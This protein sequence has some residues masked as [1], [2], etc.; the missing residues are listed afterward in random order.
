MVDITEEISVGELVLVRHGQASFN[1]DNYDRLSV[2]GERQ[3]RILGRFFASRDIEFSEAVCGDMVRHSDTL[4]AVLQSTD[5]ARPPIRSVHAGLNEYDFRTL[6]TRYVE[7]QPED[8]LVIDFLNNRSDTKAFY[9]LLRRV[10][11]AWSL[12]RLAGSGETWAEFTGRVA[13][14]RTALETLAA[15]GKRILVVASGG[16][17]S[18]IVGQTLGLSPDRIFDLNLQIYNT[19]ISRLFVGRSRVSLA[20]FNEIPHL[21]DPELSRLVSY[22]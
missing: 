17:I 19:S 4:E 20:S 7:R 18:S 16:S 12:G 14:A 22:G 13:A 3:A 2:L 15:T 6:V 10:L 1:D 21:T 5:Q 8:D 11:H 9:R